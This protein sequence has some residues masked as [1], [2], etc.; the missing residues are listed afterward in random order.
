MNAIDELQLNDRELATV[1]AALRYW[2]EHEERESRE[3]YA[4]AP[5]ESLERVAT[6]EDRF[7]PLDFDE[8]DA[9][10]LRLNGGNG[11]AKRGHPKARLRFGGFTI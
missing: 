2:Q 8:I 6:Q 10:C 9:L 1:L 5:M 4:V 11:L 3:N 7:A